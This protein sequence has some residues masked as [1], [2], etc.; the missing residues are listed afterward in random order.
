[1]L[2]KMPMQNK[3]KLQP[4]LYFQNICIVTCDLV[5]VQI[6][7]LPCMQNGVGIA[8]SVLIFDKNSL[9]RITTLP[10]MVYKMVQNYLI[11]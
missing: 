7:T 2:Y 10:M 6:N 1:M 4:V 11:L 8:F 5:V 3:F 9:V